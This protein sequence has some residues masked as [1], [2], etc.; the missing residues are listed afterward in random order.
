MKLEEPEGA[1]YTGSLVPPP[2]DC[3]STNIPEVCI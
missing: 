3:N 2:A 1:I